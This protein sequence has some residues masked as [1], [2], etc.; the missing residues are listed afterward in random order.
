MHPRSVICVEN[1]PHRREGHHGDGADRDLAR[2]DRSDLRQQ[3]HLVAPATQYASLAY[4]DRDGIRANG[5]ALA[6]NE[7]SGDDELTFQFS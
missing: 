3:D 4:R 5:V 1:N 7:T 6:F 2:R